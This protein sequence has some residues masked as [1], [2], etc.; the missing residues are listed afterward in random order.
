[1]RQALSFR[2]VADLNCVLAHGDLG[3]GLGESEVGLVASRIADLC[4]GSD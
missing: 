1:M 2:Q 3:S 4:P